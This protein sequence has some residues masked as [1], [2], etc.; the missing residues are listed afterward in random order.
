MSTESK[1][2]L[3]VHRLPPECNNELKN[4]KEHAHKVTSWRS[5]SNT[6]KES[7]ESLDSSEVETILREV[8]SD[9]SV[10]PLFINNR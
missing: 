1:K 8:E 6:M 7:I 3:N 9:V 4:L 5:I 10:I 2:N